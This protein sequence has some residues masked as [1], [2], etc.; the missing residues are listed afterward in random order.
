[1]TPAP[2]GNAPEEAVVPG[3]PIDPSAPLPVGR[4]TYRMVGATV[5]GTSGGSVK[6]SRGAAA[7]EVARSDSAEAIAAVVATV[8]AITAEVATSFDAVGGVR[9]D[10][11]GRGDGVLTGARTGVRCAGLSGV[12]MASPDEWS[13]LSIGSTALR[14]G[15]D[16]IIAQSIDPAALDSNRKVRGLDIN[17]ATLSAFLVQFD[18]RLCR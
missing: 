14:V 7:F 13:Y 6:M 4:V 1:M 8:A 17:K 12:V 9:F 3:L 2:F 15:K 18:R 5:V 11:A 10:R 16:F